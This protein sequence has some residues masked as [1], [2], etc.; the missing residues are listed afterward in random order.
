MWSI[1]SSVAIVSAAGISGWMEGDRGIPIPLARTQ[2][3]TESA[4]SGG[5]DTHVHLSAD[6]LT[7]ERGSDGASPRSADA[8]DTGSWAVPLTI[9]PGE[10]PTMRATVVWRRPKKHCPARSRRSPHA[11]RSGH[12]EMHVSYRSCAGV[13]ILAPGPVSHMCRRGEWRWGDTARPC[14]IAE[15][16]YDRAAPGSRLWLRGV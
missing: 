3:R 13:S 6:M 11:V 9:A 8:G 12:W 16:R 15:I 1:G 4:G 10:A 2:Q 7:G 14:R 5:C